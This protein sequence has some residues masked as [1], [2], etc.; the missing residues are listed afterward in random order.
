MKSIPICNLF[1]RVA[2]DITGPLLEI[3]NGN[4]YVFI[5]IDHYSKWCEAQPVKEHDVC[6]TAKF[7]EDEICRYGVPM[8]V[9]TNNGSEWMKDFAEIC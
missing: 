4:K 7:L 6:T 8:Y 5:T 2:M 1:N 9:L 3:I